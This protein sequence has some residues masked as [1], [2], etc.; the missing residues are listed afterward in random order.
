LLE[1][2]WCLGQRQR[3]C[4]VFAEA[5]QRGVF[6]EA[7]S[8]SDLMWSI[9][10]HRM[11]VG[12]AMTTLIV[13]L[14]DLEAEIKKEKSFPPLLSIVTKWG[15]KDPSR[16]LKSLPVARAMLGSLTDL[17]APF[18]FAQWNEGRIVT[19]APALENWLATGVQLEKHFPV[20]NEP[21]SAILSR[22]TESKSYTG[23][24]G[25]SLLTTL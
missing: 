19:W 6:A 18:D 11:S 1:A 12:A 25:R 10:V 23:R 17:G 13:W 3:A 22:K 14:L 5:R 2:L 24:K 4:R 9:D 15:D 7:F 20:T 8:H 16:D 21:L